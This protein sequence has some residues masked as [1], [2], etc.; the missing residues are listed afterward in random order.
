[1][2]APATSTA[3]PAPAPKGLVSNIQTTITSEGTVVEHAISSWHVNGW[4]LVGAI[5]VAN[6]VGVFLHL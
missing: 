1:M 2:A 6:V 4:L 3:T 5:V